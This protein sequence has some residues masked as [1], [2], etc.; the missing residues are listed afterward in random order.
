M[1]LQNWLD[2]EPQ[3]LS[4]E[5]LR[6]VKL[7]GYDGAKSALYD[8]VRELRPGRSERLLPFTPAPGQLTQHDFGHAVVPFADGSSHRVHFFATRLTYS[9]WTTV[10]IIPDEEI[11]TLLDALSL[12]FRQVGGIPL[13]ALFDRPRVV[14]RS[15]CRVGTTPTW[16]PAVAA[17]ALDLGLGLDVCWR[18]RDG[19]NGAPDSVVAWVKAKFFKDRSFADAADVERQ[20]REWLGEINAAPG[21]RPDGASPALRLREEQARLRP[22]RHRASTASE[23]APS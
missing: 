18:H 3:L 14:A 23:R 4:V 22:V 7:I 21:P 9:R 16:H 5:L 20:L 10:S 15:D 19:P 1:A 6:R 8:L 11:D 12:H 13:L 17:M 2:E